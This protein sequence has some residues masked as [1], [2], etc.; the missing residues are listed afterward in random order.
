VTPEEAKAIDRAEF[1][2]DCRAA[3]ERAFVFVSQR[4]THVD[5]RVRLWL[6]KEPPKAHAIHP[7]RNYRM[8]PKVEA[9]PKPARKPRSNSLRLSNEAQITLT[10]RGNTMT[11]SEWSDALGI[12]PR[13]LRSRIAYGWPVERILTESASR[14]K[15]RAT[16][17]RDYAPGVATDFP[18][19]PATGAPSNA[20]DFSQLEISE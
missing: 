2:A 8:K 12:S 18:D 20:R 15:P 19:I 4:R 11:L 7:L 6:G 9:K 3:R 1:E 16:T 13:T 5:E 17:Q 10:Y 14:C